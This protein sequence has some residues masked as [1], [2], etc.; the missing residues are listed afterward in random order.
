M[1]MQCLLRGAEPTVT[2]ANVVLGYLPTELAGG[3]IT[4]DGD[5]T[6]LILRTAA[7]EGPR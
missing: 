5:D 6:A 2:D 3:E 1:A 7:V 4:L